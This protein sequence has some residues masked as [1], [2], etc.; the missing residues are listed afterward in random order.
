MDSSVGAGL[1]LVSVII[2]VHNAAATIVRALE[3]VVAQTYKGSIEIII[4]DDASSDNSS[5]LIRCFCLE[6]TA[7]SK[8]VL[9]LIESTSAS[10]RGPAY[11]R[12]RAVER[13]TG[14][15]LCL[16]DSDDVCYPHR[17]EAQL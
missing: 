7:V 1:P 14:E 6:L 11:A 16:L 9:H 2:P 12:N 4:Y 17:I 8:I 10:A 13:S 5:D 15:Y 3:S